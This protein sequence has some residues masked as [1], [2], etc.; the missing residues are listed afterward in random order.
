MAVSSYSLSERLALL[1]KE[2]QEAALDGAPG[3]VQI[4]AVSKKK[5]VGA[6]LEAYEAGQRHFGENYVQELVEKSKDLQ[7]KL[8]RWHFIGHLQSNKCNSLC[9]VQ[10]LC[11]VHSVDSIKLAMLLDRAWASQGRKDNLSVYVQVNTSREATK[12]GVTPENCCSVV[13]F[14]L[15]S[16]K[17]LTFSGLMTIGTP[18]GSEGSLVN[19]DFQVLKDCKLKVCAQ[20]GLPPQEVLL[21]M[22]MSSDYRQAVAAGADVVRIGTALFGPRE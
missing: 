2:I 5:S 6:I 10:N 22:G 16:C 7:D 12:S 18:T 4:V 8:I 3:K 21:N 15:H 11:A 17:A 13:D 14:V 9:S 19:G 1:K 20:F